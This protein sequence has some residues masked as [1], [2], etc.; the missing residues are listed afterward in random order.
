MQDEQRQQPRAPQVA[1]E[2]IGPAR[3]GRAARGRAPGASTA[4]R[5]SSTEAASAAAC[6]VF[7]EGTAPDY[8][9]AV[10][11]AG[12]LAAATAAAGSSTR[13]GSSVSRAMT[14]RWICEVPS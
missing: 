3:P 4:A 9:E 7:L 6:V 14:R 13:R 2:R 10:P 8:P 12:E 11:P 5:A 1:D